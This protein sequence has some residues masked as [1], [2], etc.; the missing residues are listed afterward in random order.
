MVTGG[1]SWSFQTL[2]LKVFKTE[3]EKLY[4]LIS[5]TLCADNVATFKTTRIWKFKCLKLKNLLN[6]IS[7]NLT[8]HIRINIYNFVSY[9]F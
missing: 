6:Y 1:R 9:V 4:V 8:Y 2:N 7:I 3:E 5:I